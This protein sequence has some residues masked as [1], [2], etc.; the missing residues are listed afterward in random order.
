MELTMPKGRAWLAKLAGNWPGLAG[1]LVDTMI[2]KGR[3]KQ[4]ALP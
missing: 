1:M 3:K 2:N 4:A